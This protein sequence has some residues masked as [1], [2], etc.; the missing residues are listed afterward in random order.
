LSSWR[1]QKTVT[2]ENGGFRFTRVWPGL[3]YGIYVYPYPGDTHKP[4]KVVKVAEGE[5]LEVLVE[6]D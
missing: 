2:N 3:E 5:T 1:E 4:F 6:T